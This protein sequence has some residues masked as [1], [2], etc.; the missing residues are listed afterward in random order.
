MLLSQ[1]QQGGS[2]FVWNNHR[3]FC[4]VAG[5]GKTVLLVHGFPTSSMDWQALW[6][7]LQQNYRLYTLDMLGFGLSDKPQDFKYS[8][9]ASADQWQAFVLAHGLSEVAIVAHDY[10]DTVVQELLARQHE[11]TLPFRIS[12]VSLLNGGLFPEATFPILM[13]KLLLS[14]IG[15][16]V[17]RLSNF[18]SF[19]RSM[20][21]IAGS[22]LPDDL[23]REHWHLVVRDNG[24]VVLP[25]IIQYI[26]ERKKYRE[27]WSSALQNAGIPL[28]LIIG[29]QDPISGRTIAARWRQLLPNSRV[30]EFDDVGHYPQWEA[31]ERVF[32]ALEITHS[33]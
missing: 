29:N 3:L 5:Q 32:S 27:R 30:I 14:R 15:P 4:R 10:G 1:W 17:A 21:K 25:K 20:Q 22:R 33:V 28:Q 9:F 8:L 16:L 18:A 11:G 2:E 12:S 31:P 6:P 19:A 26:R 13:Q 23:L 7:L 24:R